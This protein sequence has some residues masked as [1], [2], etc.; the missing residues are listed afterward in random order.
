MKFIARRM[1]GRVDCRPH[2]VVTIDPD[3]AK[4]FDDAI[5]LQRE[6][7]DQWRLWVHIADVSHYVKPG[8]RA[9]RG[10]AQARQLDLSRG[11]RH[12]DAAGGVEQRAVLAQAGGG[13]PDQVRRVPD[14]GR[15]AGV[16]HEVLSAVIHS[17]RRFTYQ[18][19]L[20]H[21]A[22]QARAVPSSRCCT[23]RMNWRRSIR[24]LRFKAGSLDLDFPETKIRL[25]E[26][27]RVVAHR[28]DGERRLASVD[29]GMH[30]AGQR[31]GGRPADAA[32]HDRPFIA[33]T[34]R[35]TSGGCRNI[36]RKC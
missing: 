13:S 14:F 3:D 1:A 28:E 30:A 27:G 4:D 8:I 11:P 20:A 5:C 2:Q 33:S 23:R 29:R 34:K 7:Q 32:A 31:S 15:R 10:G 36:A 35:R 26:R 6:S 16:E 25:D 22:T 9:G 21:S 18:E 17:Q 19:V 24:R 12:S